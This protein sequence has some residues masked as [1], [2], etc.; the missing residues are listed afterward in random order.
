MGPI[1]AVSIPPSRAVGSSIGLPEERAQELDRIS[2]EG[3]EAL[4]K[5]ERLFAAGRLNDA[6]AQCGVVN[7]IW[8][9]HGD[10]MN[11]GVAHLL[12]QIRMREGR[13][14]EAARIMGP[15][16]DTTQ[17]MRLDFALSLVR[18]GQAE[19]ARDAYDPSLI[20]GYDSAFGDV[21][22]YLPQ[23]RTVKD[24]EGALL[25]NKAEALRLFGRGDEAVNFFAAALVQFPKNALLGAELGFH[26]QNAHR[27]AEA[28]R[29]YAAVR[30]SGDARLKAET[31]HDYERVSAIVKASRAKNESP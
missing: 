17:L 22:N 27:Y 2:R 3:G 25:W 8:D 18:S 28:E 24:L 20:T 30:V 1:G 9:S 13:Y 11:P 12:G 16:L 29:G 5:A 26:A 6:E 10:R 7:E 31:Q 19:R 4:T 21:R 15:N 23:I 14:A